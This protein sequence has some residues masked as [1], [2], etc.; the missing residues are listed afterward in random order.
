L[1]RAHE[2][3]AWLVDLDG[4]LYHALP[5]RMAMACSLAG[6]GWRVIRVI[7]HFRREQERLRQERP[8][9]PGANPFECQLRR[10]AACLG[11]ETD[12]VR[13]VIQC[14][15]FDRPARW[16][17]V[18]QRTKLI[19]SIRQFR[20]RGG[21]TALVSDYPARQKLNA[22]G[23]A[24][25]FDAVVACGEP[26]GPCRLKPDPEGV[27]L[28]AQLLAVAPSA[29]L[30]IGDRWDVDRETACRANMAF[31]D[32]HLRRVVWPVSPLIA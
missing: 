28:A 13:S 26:Q 3:T 12:S 25:L 24:D 15:M 16:F 20:E 32:A 1:T 8:E 17:R 29:C 21:R 27:L 18:F 5:I 30:V 4:T 19:G 9:L 7:R 11:L 6:A 14:W 10:T 31:A 23:V 22:L 2:F